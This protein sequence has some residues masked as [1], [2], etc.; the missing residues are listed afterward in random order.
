MSHTRGHTAQ[1]PCTD[2]ASFRR[3]RRTLGLLW[4]ALC[5]VGCASPRVSSADRGDSASGGAA[6][7]V[8]VS[9]VPPTTFVTPVPLKVENRNSND[10]TIWIELQDQRTRIGS[11][12]GSTTRDFTLPA[13]FFEVIGTVRLAAETAG[14]RGPRV[15]ASDQIRVK[16]V[17][18]ERLLIRP[19]QRLVWTLES[20]LE[21]SHLGIF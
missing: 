11:V 5:I 12:T 16:R 20:T 1:M 6:S 9:S 13:R 14:A 15:D 21:R 10:V 7:D 4:T 17:T 18:T 8:T 3:Q 2:V 19:G